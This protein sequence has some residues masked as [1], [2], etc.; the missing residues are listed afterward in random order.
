MRCWSGCI[1]NLSSN[2][3]DTDRTQRHIEILNDIA[4]TIPEVML[5]SLRDNSPTFLTDSVAAEEDIDGRV[6]S[7][8]EVRSGIA[9]LIEA[10]PALLAEAE[11][12]VDN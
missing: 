11:Q 4:L 6:D 9:S 2:H 3:A 5:L 7:A 8:E 10:R 12:Y 1:R